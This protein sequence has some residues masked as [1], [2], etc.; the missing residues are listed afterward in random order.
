M[1]LALQCCNFVP[2]LSS[3]S[4][5]N[6]GGRTCFFKGC[7][8]TLATTWR[9]LW[10]SKR[11]FIAIDVSRIVST[12]PWPAAF[13]VTEV[14]EV[15]SAM[16]VVVLLGLVF[17]AAGHAM[18]TV[19][20][21]KNNGFPGS[22]A[23]DRSDYYTT[24]SWWLDRAYFGT[25]KVTPWMQPGHFSWSLGRNFKE[26]VCQVLVFRWVEVGY[27]ML[28][29]SGPMHEIYRM[30]HKPFILAVATILTVWSSALASS[31][32][33][34][35]VRPPWVP[36]LAPRWRHPDGHGE[37]SKLLGFEMF[38]SQHFCKTVYIRIL[39]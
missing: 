23:L 38:E 4:S 34:A 24:A 37:H 21:S 17:H 27:V 20:H 7:V 25:P 22:Y 29:C 5:R 13:W 31:W 19:P 11:T 9:C 8:A 1:S 16:A 2:F 6:A 18:L 10:V 35:S 15:M 32:H 26:F 33:K 36:P 14:T 30:W 39:K 28:K 3:Q 12:S